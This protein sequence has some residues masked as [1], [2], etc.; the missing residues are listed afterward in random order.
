MNIFDAYGLRVNDLELARAL[1]EDVIGH[2]E[3]HESSYV[4]EYY[5]LTTSDEENYILQPNFRDDDWA[6]ENYKYCGYLL[7]VNESPK[8][9]EIR[10]KLLSRYEDIIEFIRRVIYTKNGVRSEYKYTDGKDILVSEREQSSL[11]YR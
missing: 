4:G 5:V 8:R 6:E 9:D 3:L 11:N 2:M 10:E 1:I 7:Y